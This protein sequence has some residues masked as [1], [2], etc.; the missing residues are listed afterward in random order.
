MGLSNWIS[1]KQKVTEGS[2][3]QETKEKGLS[4]PK[5]ECAGLAQ[6]D[7]PWNVYFMQ[8]GAGD[9]RLI[10]HEPVDLQFLNS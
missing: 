1:S 7:F 8:V 3:S 5:G 6:V 10:I 4:I 2:G 9:P